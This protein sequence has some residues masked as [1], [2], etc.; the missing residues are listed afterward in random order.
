MNPT[1]FK[2]IY[3]VT[4]E[5]RE[6]RKKNA[7]SSGALI[8][9]RPSTSFSINY[10]LLPALHASL[11][12]FETFNSKQWWTKMYKDARVVSASAKAAGAAL[13]DCEWWWAGALGEGKSTKP[14]T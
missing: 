12:V 4:E 8:R 6:R 1:G 13:R 11:D 2:I 5:K 14:R 3:N 10:Q 7:R 9:Q